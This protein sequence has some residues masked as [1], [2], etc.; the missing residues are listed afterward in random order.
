MNTDELK[1]LDI[2]QSAIARMAANSFQLKGW[3]VALGT[4]I[5]GLTAKDAQAQLAVLTLL[6]AL[7]FCYLDAYY[8]GLERGFRDLYE[9][10]TKNDDPPG[11]FSMQPRNDKTSVVKALGSRSV[12]A[13]HGTIALV[14]VLVALWGVGCKD[15]HCS[16]L[17]PGP[18][19]TAAA[20]KP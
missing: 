14:A 13:V 5:I 18:T 20:T 6:P 15:G 3:S 2:L 19:P 10:Y 9:R 11:L 12:W 16:V 1:Y 8:L 17:S 7:V 4:V